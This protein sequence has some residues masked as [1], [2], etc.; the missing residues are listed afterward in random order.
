VSGEPATSAL[1]SAGL[2]AVVGA[3]AGIA[4]WVATAARSRW[5]ARAL[6][7]PRLDP[8][9]RWVS[10]EV[11]RSLEAL[12]AEPGALAAPEAALERGLVL[13]AV[14]ERLSWRGGLARLTPL[15][16]RLPVD[17]DADALRAELAL[18][19]GQIDRARTL[20]EALPPDHWRACAVRARL[21]EIDG[22]VE[23]ADAAWVAARHLAPR[24]R[25]AGLSLLLSALRSRHGRE[26]GEPLTLWERPPE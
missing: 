16:E 26:I 24:D 17:P 21:Y 13:C 1:V 14:D 22:D 23:R 20:L 4:A 2:C 11:R 12:L 25:R 19:L 8:A 6:R 7:D 10:A 15:A 5:L 9:A 18:G 3:G